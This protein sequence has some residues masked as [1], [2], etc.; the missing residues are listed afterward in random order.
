LKRTERRARASLG[1]NVL[2]FENGEIE[3][4]KSFKSIG[5]D[6]KSFGLLKLAGGC[7]LATLV[8][9][10]GSA[11]EEGKPTG[12]D[13]GPKQTDGEVG[14]KPKPKGGSSLGSEE[15]DAGVGKRQKPKGGSSLG[16]E[17]TDAGV[18]K[19]QKPKGESSL[20]PKQTDGQVD[21]KPKAKGW[22]LGPKQTDANPAQKAK[23]GSV[24]LSPGQQNT[25]L[26]KELKTTGGEL[27]GTK[28]SPPLPPQEIQHMQQMQQTK[29]H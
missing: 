15:T 14:K 7:L 29:A 8:L 11:A 16:S 18:G 19:R 9:V 10:R 4:L 5:F 6:L 20:D 13:L 1:P 26:E 12:W 21:K 23:A 24:I 27:R 22:D 2:R 28:I 25:K 17:E 3:M